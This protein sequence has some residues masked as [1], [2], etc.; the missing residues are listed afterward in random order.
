MKYVFFEEP[1]LEFGNGGTHIDMRFGIATHGPLDLGDTKAP[2]QVKLGLIGTEETIA[3]VRGWFERCKS[4]IPRKDSK[5]ANLFPDFPGFS[6]ET[7]FRSSLVFHD[8]WCASI[9]QREIDAVLAHSD[10]DETVRQAVAMFVDR[11]DEL[12]QQGGPMVLVCVPPHDLLA[13]V[14]ERRGGAPDPDQQELD[15]GSEPADAHKPPTISFHDF[16]KAE[17]MR[18]SVPLQMVRPKTYQ[19]RQQG[20]KKG[21]KKLSTPLQDEATR[22]WN[23]HTALYYKAGGIPWRL[24]R[25][26]AELTTCFVG[27]SFYRS[28]D[29]SRLLTSVAQV[30]NER[31]EGVIVKGGQA[32]L[33][34]DDK[35]PHLSEADAHALLQKAIHVYRQEH[36]T[37]PA[38]VVVHKTSRV[39]PEEATGFDAAAQEHSI[40]TVELLTVRRSLTRLFREG[41]YPP[42]RG[43]FVELQS[44]N[45]LLYLKG[46]VNFFETYPGMYV[47]RPLEFTSLRAEKPLDQLA[48]EMLSLSK[49]NWNNTQFDG[50]EPITVRAARRVGDILKCVPEGGKVQPTFR[51][52]M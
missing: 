40:D 10:G 45:G 52:F 7:S 47:P 15:E 20:K 38:R 32:Q 46:S 28:L 41:T 14:D 25:E 19:G 51:F 27:I 4:G 36:K 43:T 31:G 22:A 49:L 29:Q 39:T 35:T 17:G 13:A 11:A 26:A 5:L 3:A 8:R 2:T 50:G 1:D 33:D 34:K 48:R 23:I 42:F 16:L 12:V 30:F 21:Q 37:S 9:R 18:L 44:T 6:A 24:L